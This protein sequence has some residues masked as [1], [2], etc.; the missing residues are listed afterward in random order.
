MIT[1]FSKSYNIAN[2]KKDFFD[3]N[4]LNLKS[5]IKINNFYK[6]QKKRIR[7]KI[8]SNKLKNFIINFGI[9]YALCKKCN[10]LNGE[11]E[12]TKKFSEW[13]YTSAKGSNY[14]RNYLSNYNE[15]VKKIYIPKVD[16]LKKVVKKKFNLL[17]VG[18]GG[19][20]FVRALEIKKINA[21]GV[22]PS[23]TLSDLGNK[24]LKKNILKNIPLDEIYKYMV[25]QKKIDV[26]SAIGVLEHVNNPIEFIR[27]FKK[28]KAQYLYISVPL[29]SLSVFLEN[30]FTKVFPRHLSGG[31][32][33]LFTKESLYFLAKKN[34]LKIIGEWWFGTD[35]PDLYRSLLQSQNYTNRNL[36][37]K[38]IDKYLFDMIDELQSVLDKKKRCS[39]VHMVFKKK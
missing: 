11:Y 38:T 20:H 18:S 27:N 23:K 37:K 39:Q 22:E 8:C 16:F 14:S 25:D 4:D 21:V 13:L 28:S 31:H 2:I 33:H 10:H 26:V 36:F 19:G 3:N 29:F 15:R 6:K 35:L 32:T 24:V 30:S 9:K 1:K 7:C 17:D 5:I 12:D 34:N